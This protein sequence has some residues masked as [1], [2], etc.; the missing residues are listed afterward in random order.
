MMNAD[1]DIP[2]DHKAR[3]VN[4]TVG[5]KQCGD[6]SIRLILLGNAGAGK[7]SLFRKFCK[8][9]FTSQPSLTRAIDF[10]IIYAYLDTACAEVTQIKLFDIPGDERCWCVVPQYSRDVQGA[11]YVFDATDPKSFRDL[12][13]WR[14]MLHAGTADCARI[15]VGTKADMYSSLDALGNPKHTQWLNDKDL[16][17]ACKQLGADCGFKLV[18]SLTGKN[19]M[20]AVMTVAAAAAKHPDAPHMATLNL[21]SPRKSASTRKDTSK[22]CN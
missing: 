14:K 1:V 9:V 10:E 2:I 16:A 15:L 19:V 8:D 6:R 3:I 18:S 11:I 20:E 13:E 7:T 22:C 5:A 12:E 4:P 17:A 21:N